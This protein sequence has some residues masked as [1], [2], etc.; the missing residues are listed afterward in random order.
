MDCTICVCFSCF[1]FPFFPLREF[2]EF[3]RSHKVLGGGLIERIIGHR[4]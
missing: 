2:L 1:S 4:I 3:L